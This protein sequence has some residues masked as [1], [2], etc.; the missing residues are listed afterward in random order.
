MLC[1]LQEVFEFVLVFFNILYLYRE[2][3]PVLCILEEV[4]GQHLE[5]AAVL[6]LEDM[7]KVL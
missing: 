6:R 4:P 5:A 1:I 7:L 3:L 2:R